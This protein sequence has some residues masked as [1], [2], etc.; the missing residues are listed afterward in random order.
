MRA[1][2]R[3]TCARAGSVA[4][5]G[6]PPRTRARGPGT[7]PIAAY[8]APSPLAVAMM[9]GTHAVAAPANQLPVRPTPVTTSSKHTRKPCR[10]RR[11]ASPSQNRSGRGVRGKRCGADG[12]AEERRHVA[13]AGFLER[14][15][16]RL[17]RRLAGRVEAPGARRDVQVA[18][19]VRLE[20]ADAA[21]STGERERLHRRAVIRLSRRDH[22]PALALPALDV[23]AAGELDGHLV[24]V[25]PAG[26]EAHAGEPFGRHLDQLARESLLGRVRESFVVH[27]REGVRLRPSGS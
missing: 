20:G 25:G 11:S 16:Q 6:R 13:G 19:Q 9:S 8:P 22:L 23:I 26:R 4:S 14:L 21:G 5:R 12:L 7:A 17:E 15:I 1:A 27:E 24:G 3:P 18:G 2:H 10:S